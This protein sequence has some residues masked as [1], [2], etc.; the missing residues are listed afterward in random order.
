MLPEPWY[1]CFGSSA[2]EA[3]ASLTSTSTPHSGSEETSILLIVAMSRV[4]R[5]RAASLWKRLLL[6]SGP[7]DSP[8]RAYH[9]LTHPRDGHEVHNGVLSSDEFPPKLGGNEMA[10]VDD[11]GPWLRLRPQDQLI[12]DR[13]TVYIYRQDARS[14]LELLPH[15]QPATVLISFTAVFTMM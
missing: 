3:S 6:A 8:C 5:S 9:P 15:S 10:G 11:M 12:L 7:K 13:R 1:S 4:C 14:F 2:G